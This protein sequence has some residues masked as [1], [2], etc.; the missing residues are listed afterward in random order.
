MLTN[1]WSTQGGHFRLAIEM[2]RTRHREILPI[3]KRYQRP[4]LLELRVAGRLIYRIHSTERHSGRVQHDAPFRQITL[5]EDF[6][7]YRNKRAGVVA[8]GCANHPQR[9]LDPPLRRSSR[10]DNPYTPV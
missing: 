2:K 7:Q 1:G 8:A 4:D 3:G 10:C 5:R 9:R 6:V